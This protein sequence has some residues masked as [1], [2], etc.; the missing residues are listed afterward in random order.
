MR[1]KIRQK[2]KKEQQGTRDDTVRRVCLTVASVQSNRLTRRPAV[3]RPSKAEKGQR[4]QG[5]NHQRHV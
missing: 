3:R 4:H 5:S 1:A 2:C